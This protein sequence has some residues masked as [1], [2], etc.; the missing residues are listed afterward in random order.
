MTCLEWIAM[1]A[2]YVDLPPED[3]R[4]ALSVF[5]AAVQARIESAVGRL[6]FADLDGAC[7][8]MPEEGDGVG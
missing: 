6:R 7:D 8:Y 5:P 1:L 2:W 3:F 4:L